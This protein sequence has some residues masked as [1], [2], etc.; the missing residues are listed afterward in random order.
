MNWI[1]KLFQLNR[2]VKMETFVLMIGHVKIILGKKFSTKS[3]IIT[4]KSMQKGTGNR[5]VKI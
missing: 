2:S 4:R 5:V 1:M 3:S